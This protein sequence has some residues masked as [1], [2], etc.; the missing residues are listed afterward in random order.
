M[1]GAK[2]IVL[3]A[4][5]LA[6]FF[7]TYRERIAE[8]DLVLGD[9]DTTLLLSDIYQGREAETY[10]DYDEDYNSDCGDPNQR[11]TSWLS[12]MLNRREKRKHHGRD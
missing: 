6:D 7:Q 3:Q 8:G 1:E 2:R 11:R 5:S 12:R 9:R 4:P 10:Q